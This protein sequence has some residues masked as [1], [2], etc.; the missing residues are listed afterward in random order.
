[1]FAGRFNAYNRNKLLADY[2][3][4]SLKR[5]VSNTKPLQIGG[6]FFV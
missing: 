6:A 2:N 1:M 5:K 4:K 3:F